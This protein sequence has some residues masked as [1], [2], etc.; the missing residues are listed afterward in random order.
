MMP[1]GPAEVEASDVPTSGE[2]GVAAWIPVLSHVD[3]SCCLSCL[4]ELPPFPF[5]LQ[6]L[7]TIRPDVSIVDTPLLNL[8]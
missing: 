4:G 7:F 2:L 3:V 1:V 6:Q 5:L 8:I